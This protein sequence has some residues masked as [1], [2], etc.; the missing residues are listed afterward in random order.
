MKDEITIIGTPISP[1]VRKVLAI[2]DMKGI[3][4]R[5]IPQ[6]P[7]TGDEAFT[8]ISPLRRIP[9]LQIGDFTVPDSSVIAQYLEEKFPEV[10]VYPQDPEARARARWFEEYAD[11]HIGRNVVYNLFFQRRVRP[12]VLKQE[13]DEA[14]VDKAINHELPKVLGYLEVEVPAEGFICGDFCVADIALGAMMRNAFWSDWTL[15]G[16][17][18]PGVAAYL[19]RVYAHPAMARLN[20]LAESM[21]GTSPKEHQAMVDAHFA[22]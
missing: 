19:G 11:D 14:L 16:A 8:K 3:P 9:V 6:I 1:Y 13:T 4:F 15:D 17:Q 7:F 18:W 2:L 22:A 10:N 20:T 21:L 12:A 5:C